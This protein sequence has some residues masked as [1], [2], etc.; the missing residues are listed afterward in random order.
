VESGKLESG[1]GDFS[2]QT[3]GIQDER[4]AP[5]VASTVLSGCCSFPQTSAWPNYLSKVIALRV[6]FLTNNR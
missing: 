4:V 5:E 3:A 6:Y 2:L 1:R